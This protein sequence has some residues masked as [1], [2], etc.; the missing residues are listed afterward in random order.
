MNAFDHQSTYMCKDVHT[1][2]ICKS[3]SLEAIQTFIK[4]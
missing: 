4:K 1:I 2:F 3:Q